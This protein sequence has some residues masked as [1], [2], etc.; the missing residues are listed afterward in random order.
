MFTFDV[1]KLTLKFNQHFSQLAL[2]KNRG[3]PTDEVK[4][5]FQLLSNRFSDNPEGKLTLSQVS[6]NG[7]A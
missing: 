7:K 1:A 6:L 4:L 3:L 5:G 2:L